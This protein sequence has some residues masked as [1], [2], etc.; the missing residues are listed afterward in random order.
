MIL[1]GVPTNSSR[2]W[3]VSH[4]FRSPDYHADQKLPIQKLEILYS[5]LEANTNRYPSYKIIIDE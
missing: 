4:N 5:L 3:N 1:L 2:W